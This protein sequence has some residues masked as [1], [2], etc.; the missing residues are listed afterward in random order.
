MDL[1]ILEFANSAKLFALDTPRIVWVTFYLLLST[2]DARNCKPL[3]WFACLGHAPVSIYSL[4]INHGFAVAAVVIE[5]AHA[6]A[7]NFSC[8]DKSR[9]KMGACPNLRAKSI[10]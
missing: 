4:A 10:F 8:P 9:K 6:F 1:R 5:I 7:W 3:T 2:G